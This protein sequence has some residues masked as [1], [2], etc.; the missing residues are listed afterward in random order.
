MMLR[1]VWMFCPLGLGL[2]LD[3]A[4]Q[5]GICISGG[6]VAPIGGI[7]SWVMASEGGWSFGIASVSVRQELGAPVRSGDVGAFSF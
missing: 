6:I 7:K 5:E 3:M 4:F 1:L 2:H